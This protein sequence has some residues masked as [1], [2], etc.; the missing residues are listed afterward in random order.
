MTEDE[1]FAKAM[2]GRQYGEDETRDARAWF[3]AGWEARRSERIADR[4]YNGTAAES[5]LEELLDDAGVI[6]EKTGWDYYDD[7]VEIYGVPPE[8][9]LE[10][11]TL[12][13][14]RAAGFMKAYVNHT[15]GWETHYNLMTGVP[16]RV[17]Y[18]DKRKPE[19]G[20]IWVE[21]PVP[22]WP[23]AWFESGYVL[24]MKLLG[25]KK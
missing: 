17:S 11:S 4:L 21:E 18:P 14:L 9:R 2:E 15:D 12:K 8:S 5:E 23:R 6:Y 7:S 10:Q 3:H 1:A 22:T 16:W 24:V 20:S 25:G 13:Q 19:G